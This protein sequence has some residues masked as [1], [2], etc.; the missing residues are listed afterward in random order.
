MQ[1]KYYQTIRLNKNDNIC[2]K[3][4]NTVDK[5]QIKLEFLE[6]KNLS[7]KEEAKRKQN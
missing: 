1:G 5:L 2:L 6:T 4:N 7:L 3:D